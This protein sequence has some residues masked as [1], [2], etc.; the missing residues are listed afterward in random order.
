MRSPV[1]GKVVN[2]DEKIDI[3]VATMNLISSA[4]EP[5]YPS[6]RSKLGD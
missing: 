1:V 2:A 5:R 3:E 4:N 6:P